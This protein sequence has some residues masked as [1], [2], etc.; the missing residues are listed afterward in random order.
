MR[1][2]AFYA[3]IGIVTSSLVA[4]CGGSRPA[5]P[6]QTVT[7]PV[8]TV[9]PTSP[10][11]SNPTPSTASTQKPKPKLN[12][13]DRK[14][15]IPAGTDPRTIFAVEG[16]GQK[17]DVERVSRYLPTDEFQVA[18]ADPRFN[19][20]QFVVS[21]VSSS[22]NPSVLQPGTGQPRQGLQMAQGFSVVKEAGY[23]AE[24]LPLRIICAKTGTTLALVPAGPAIV[25]T[26]T[27]PEESKPTFTVNIDAFYMEIL[28][29][30]VKSYEEFRSDLRAKKKTIPPAPSN[31]SSHPNSPALGVPWA[32]AKDYA[33]WAG[34]ELPTEAEFEKAARGPNG[35]RTPWGDGR[36]L[37]SNRTMTTTGAYPTDLSPYGILD[38]AG[39]AKEWCADLYSPTA[40]TDAV[41]AAAKE[42]LHNWPGP[43]KVKEMNLR[44]VKGNGP[45]WNSWHREGKDMGKAHMDVGFRCVLRV[46]HESKPK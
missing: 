2:T 30:T 11:Q 21:A 10:A 29:T 3:V 39:N 25:G 8:I 37:W 46:P 20:S 18:M 14:F 4:G 5:A 17:M 23:S 12:T 32:N 15:A 44:V 43:K 36:A 22:T 7:A 26:D 9:P 24:G 28:E 16:V 38:L 13:N 31:P 1:S 40:H 33:K 34:M 19:S 35:L 27:G 41:S 45:E 42:P 6:T